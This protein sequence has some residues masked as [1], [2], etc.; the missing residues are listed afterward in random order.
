MFRISIIASVIVLASS[1]VARGQDDLASA[2]KLLERKQWDK[3]IEVYEKLLEEGTSVLECRIGLCQAWLGKQDPDTASF[4]AVKAEK[5]DPKSI[6]AARLVGWCFLLK[7]QAKAAQQSDPTADYEQAILSYRRCTELEPKNAE[8]WANLGWLH[9]QLGQYDEAVAAYEKAASLDAGN[10]NYTYSVALNALNA[11]NAATDP[12]KK[13]SLKEKAAA[14][15]SKGMK[16]AKKNP[17]FL[18]PLANILNAAGH[19]NEAAEAYLEVLLAKS[20]DPNVKGPAAQGLWGVYGP[21]GRWDELIGAYEKWASAEPKNYLPSWW[22]GYAQL[23]AKRFKD[24]VATWKKVDKL[25]GGQWAQ[26]WHYLGVALRGAGQMEEAARQL[27]RAA[28][29]NYP[30]QNPQDSPQFYLELLAG[31]AFQAGK[32]DLAVKIIEQDLLPVIKQDRKIWVLNN[33]G[34]FRRD[35]GVAQERQGLK[36]AARKSYEAAKKA[37]KDAVQLIPKHPEMT[38]TQKAQLLNDYGLMYQYHFDDY[39]TA[40]KNYLAALELDPNLPDACLNVGRIYMQLGKLKEALE[41]LKRGGD[42]GDIVA[43]RKRCEQ[44]MKKKP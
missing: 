39:K 28:K 20:G 7:G 31:E 29:S 17:G 8:H 13:K 44:M 3:A 15:A 6:E 36:T 34:L 11:S 37:Y 10:L 38:A 24:A 12:A 35:L 27:A 25:S 5:A 18:A 33:L 4:H 9:Q 19:S 43:A 26:A 21:A 30:W 2:K 22:K 42:R 1:L 40:L 32:L 14:W 23:S 16:A 41:V